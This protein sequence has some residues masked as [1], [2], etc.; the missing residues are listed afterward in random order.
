MNSAATAIIREVTP[1][2]N[3]QSAQLIAAKEKTNS[4]SSKA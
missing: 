1:S 4:I 2:I 3:G